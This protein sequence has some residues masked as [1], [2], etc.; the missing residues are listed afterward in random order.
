[1]AFWE[2]PPQYMIE[3]ELRLRRTR[4]DEVCGSAEDEPACEDAAPGAPSAPSEEEEEEL[5]RSSW[6]FLAK[7]KLMELGKYVAS[8][9]YRKIRA[10]W[11]HIREL[12]NTRANSRT[13]R[14]ASVRLSAIV[15]QFC[16]PAVNVSMD[17]VVKLLTEIGLPAHSVT[18]SGKL[19]ALKHEAEL[20]GMDLTFAEQFPEEMISEARLMDMLF[21]EVPEQRASELELAEADYR[22][23]QSESADKRR[24]VKLIEDKAKKRAARSTVLFEETLAELQV[25]RG[26]VSYRGPRLNM[27][28]EMGRALSLAAYQERVR[29]AMA[30]VSQHRL[31]LDLIGPAL[32]SERYVSFLADPGFDPP[33]VWLDATEGSAVVVPAAYFHRV[34]LGGATSLVQVCRALLTGGRGLGGLSHVE[35]V[36]LLQALAATR[37]QTVFRMCRASRPYARARRMWR[38]NHRLCKQSHL[39]AWAR[40]SHAMTQYRER[41]LRKLVAWRRYTALN[42]ARRELFRLCFWPVLVWRKYAVASAVAKSKTRFLVSRV[43]PAYLLLHT[44]R[45][46]HRYSLD[47]L[48]TRRRADAHYMQRLRRKQY[49]YFQWLREGASKGILLRASRVKARLYDVRMKI[50]MRKLSY[51]QIWRGYAMFRSAVKT[52]VAR[53]VTDFRT[54][55]LGAAPKN[56]YERYWMLNLAAARRKEAARR[57]AS[58]RRRRQAE[59]RR[60]KH[61]AFDDSTTSDTNFSPGFADNSDSMELAD[62]EEEDAE[63]EEE[64]EEEEELGPARVEAKVMSTWRTVREPEA[65]DVDEDGEADPCHV[66]AALLEVYERCAP[67]LEDELFDPHLRG[68]SSKFVL[69]R[70]DNLARNFRAVEA[71]ALLDEAMVFHRAASKAFRNLQIY[72]IV[73]IRARRAISSYRLRLLGKVFRALYTWIYDV[74]PDVKSEAEKLSIAAKTARFAH[75]ERRRALQKALLAAK[76]NSPVE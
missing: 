66:P 35:T 47:R 7:E 41:C 63:E 44:Y 61:M 68:M 65:Y 69:V 73:R 30:V 9:V 28:C 54:L 50:M 43:Y 19:C 60:L 72:S 23:V 58:A 12:F 24:R 5:E 55:L 34:H 1:M 16:T 36:E 22:M 51:F 33:P 32:F 62:A 21:S 48:L 15:S 17:E 57:R 49:R 8:H 10:K 46:W 71:M 42:I 18:V 26:P 76:T 4:L 37:L 6:R 64:D 53:Y 38:R 59:R 39:K 67:S 31:L 74:Q 2:E 11:P 40:R 52:R 70:Y 29:Q 56:M 25:S 45:A 75:M 14:K 13:G 27:L 20:F 3:R